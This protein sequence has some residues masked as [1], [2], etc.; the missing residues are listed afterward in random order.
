MKNSTFIGLNDL[1]EENKILEK[2]IFETKGSETVEKIKRESNCSE[3]KYE[4]VNFKNI[5]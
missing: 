3:M 1:R 5:G 2:Y 4:E